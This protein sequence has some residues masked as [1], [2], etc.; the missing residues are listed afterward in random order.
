M[1]YYLLPQLLKVQLSSFTVPLT[2]TNLKKEIIFRI[3]YNH[4]M[5]L[6]NN[7]H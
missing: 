7:K 1:C 6:C 4:T 2:N 5:V 3:L